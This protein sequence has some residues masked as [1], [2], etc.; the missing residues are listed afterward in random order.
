MGIRGLSKIDTPPKNRLPVQTY[1][2]EKNNTLIKQVIER[3]LARDGQVFYLY[4]R[5]D[6]IAN[7]AYKNFFYCS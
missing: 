5:T 2:V 7:V 6:Q 3:E 4:N 1:V